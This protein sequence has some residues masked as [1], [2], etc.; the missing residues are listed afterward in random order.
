M[1]AN[2]W[3]ITAAVL[4][5]QIMADEVY[6]HVPRDRL[7]QG[8]K[9]YGLHDPMLHMAGNQTPHL[10]SEERKLKGRFRRDYLLLLRQ[11]VTLR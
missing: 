3:R 1:L 6:S 11:F 8:M 4:T 2:F 5:K 9:K 7:E 10:S